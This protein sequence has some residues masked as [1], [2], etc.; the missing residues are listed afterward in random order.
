MPH[1]ITA[2][3]AQ[4]P[5]A[6][7]ALGPTRRPRRVRGRRGSGDCSNVRSQLRAG[8]HVSG[9]SGSPRRRQGSSLRFDP[10]RGADG[11]DE[12]LGRATGGQL[13]D[14]RQVLPGGKR[15]AMVRKEQRHVRH[16]DTPSIEVTIGR[17]TRLYHAFVTTAPA[18]LDAPSTVTLYAG[19][20]KD[21]AGFAGEELTF[22]TT[23]AATP[24][25]LVLIDTTELGWQRAR[26][27]REPIDCCRPTRCW[28]A[29]HLAAVALAA[30]AGAGA[31]AR[32][33]AHSSTPHRE[34]A[35]VQP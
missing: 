19:P 3:T 32:V 17:Q 9:F 7:I 28:W 15:N 16:I 25:R 1:R 8:H 24:S 27:R 34:R 20:L 31:S 5:S 11:L 33:N 23:K 30:A 22:D 35:G 29:S 26:C 6:R 10:L 2:T 14:A 12:R 18:T 21:V 13:R 4:D